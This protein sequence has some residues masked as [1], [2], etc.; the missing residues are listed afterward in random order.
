M[1]ARGDKFLITGMACAACQAHVSRA[2]SALDGVE[3]AEVNLLS[4]TA[5]VFYKD[6]PC[7]TE[8]IKAIQ[9]VGYQ[10][11]LL[12]DENIWQGKNRQKRSEA[13]QA[14]Q[15]SLA[16]RCLI[17]LVLLL[18]LSACSTS[19]MF[20][21]PVDILH[22]ALGPNILWF[23]VAQA[24]LALLAML[25]NGKI[26]SS[27]FKSLISGAPNMDALVCMGTLAS[28]AYSLFNLWS[29]DKILALIS[30]SALDCDTFLIKTLH[31]YLSAT[32]F[33]SC[34]FILFFVTLGKYLEGRA[35][36]KTSLAL[37]K[38]VD[39]APQTA[40]IKK[41]DGSEEERPVSLVLVGDTIIMRPG[42]TVPVDGIIV[43]GSSSLDESALTGES[44]PVVKQVGDVALSGSVNC[45][46]AFEFVASQVGVDTTLA[47]IIRLVDEASNS[48][49]PSA[50]LADKVSR[51]FVPIVFTLALITGLLWYYVPLWFD[52]SAPIYWGTALKYGVSVLVVACPCALGLASPVAIMV[53]MGRAAQFGILVR[54]AQSLEEL[55]SA[56]AVIFDK[57]GTITQG[58]PAIVDYQTFCEAK[59]SQEEVLVYALSL[60]Q[61]SRH[62]LALAVVQAAQDKGLKPLPVDNFQEVVGGGVEGLIEKQVW[63]IGSRGYMAKNIMNDCSSGKLQSINEYEAQ[64]YSI[65][66][67]AN[68][69]DNLVGIIVLADQ[70]RP[71]SC[72]AVQSLHK[73]G[74]K[75]IILTGDRRLAAEPVAEKIEADALYAEVLPSQKADIVKKYKAEMGK[76]IVVGDGINDAPALKIADVGIAIGTGIDIAVEAADVVLM[77]NSLLDIV[78]AIELSKAVLGNI[79]QNLFWAFA[80]NVL[81]IPVAAGVF[82]PWGIELTP[83]LAALAMS[84]SSVT[85]VGNA[86]R[87][88]GFYPSLVAQVKQSRSNLSPK[89]KVVSPDN[90]E[91]KPMATEEK[92]MTKIL[93]IE[94]MMCEKCEMHVTKA[95]ESIEGV[96]VGRIERK[97]NMV[98]V[99]LSREV[100]AEVL[101]EAVEK[102]GYKVENIVG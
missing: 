9:E 5:R 72:E 39:L 61:N 29:I 10:A 42:Q 65:L 59:Y 34:A 64:G 73:L 3:Q 2:I 69:K 100:S 98:V 13:A 33:D 44:L 83:S 18:P 68:Q 80:Y 11:E 41:A 38:L 88:N 48:Q 82:S 97:Q 70:L 89:R 49:A 22:I 67:L 74:I 50:R 17:T 4:G 20:G 58:K 37:E 66:Y 27:G 81:A 51:V 90:Q 60:E 78:R 92:T 12:K 43:S 54:N 102:A 91:Q 45:E 30:S 71:D 46:G 8:V 53:G 23:V 16:L 75:A 32:Y 99:E 62:P 36:A 85:V 84:L 86:L 24:L 19:M 87:L 79:R 21:W 1:A 94:G 26:F 95:L 52:L 93:Y 35:K 31:G 6:Q 25:I 76:I 77:K 56:K 47:Q 96:K 7:A 57:T 28:F 15:R 101:R 63:K 14:E 40:L 55:S